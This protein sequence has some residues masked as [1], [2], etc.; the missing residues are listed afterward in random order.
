MYSR[1]Y[2]LKE[3]GRLHLRLSEER[4][5]SVG[6]LGHVVEQAVDHAD[7]ELAKLL[8]L[9]HALGDVAQVQPAV[10]QLDVQL[11]EGGREQR[12]K[13]DAIKAWRKT[14]G[15]QAEVVFSCG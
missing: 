14:E 1:R 2:P 3:P 7:K 15:E 5:A 10:L 12:A 13:Y 4:E 11:Q 8:V 6:I 9:G